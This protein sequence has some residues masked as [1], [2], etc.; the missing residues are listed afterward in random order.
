MTAPT[1]ILEMVP[2]EIVHL[3]Q[4]VAQFVELLDAPQSPDPDRADPA[5]RRLVPDAYAD[6]EAAREFRSLTERDLLGRRHDD[7]NAVLASLDDSPPTTDLDAAESSTGTVIVLDAETARSWLRTL[8]AIR[9]VLAT[10]LGITGED[11]HDDDDPRFGIYD[12]LGFR[13]DRLV[14]ALDEA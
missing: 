14:R 2:L 11:D 12:W 8:A 6:P 5:V 10:R 1:V 9:L 4:L 3:R 13:L 7:A